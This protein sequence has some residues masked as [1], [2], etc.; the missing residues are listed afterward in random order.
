[1]SWASS[2]HSC[3]N[4]GEVP[5][6]TITAIPI[7]TVLEVTSFSLE[8]KLFVDIPSWKLS[9]SLGVKRHHP[10]WSG[11]KLQHRAVQEAVESAKGTETI[12]KFAMVHVTNICH[13]C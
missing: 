13:P 11:E 2:E 12:K 10:T 6:L 8:L 3:L 7:I 4:S 1:M 9:F 5:L